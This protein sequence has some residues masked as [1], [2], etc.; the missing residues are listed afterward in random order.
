L[1]ACECDPVLL[2]AH[3]NAVN[4]LRKLGR[5]EEAL[6]V[7]NAI[8][9]RH[10][11]AAA[12]L[13]NAG[14]LLRDLLRPREAIDAYRRAIALQPALAEAHCNLGTL[15][16]QQGAFA[17][18]IAAFKEALALAPDL[19][20]A[21]CNLGAAYE[22]LGQP[23]E[24]AAAYRR[25]LACDP[26][27]LGVRLQIYHQR[28]NACDWIGLDI[29]APVIAAALPTCRQ[30]IVPFHLLNMVAAP[31]LHL[32][33]ARL[34]AS[35][36][37]VK[38]RFTHRQPEADAK[39]K[40]RLKIGYLSAD[41]S[42][43][44]TAHLAIDLFETHD[45]DKFEIIAYSYGH[46]DGSAMR[47]RLVRAFDTFIDLRSFDDRQAARKIFDDGV[48][49]LVELKGYTQFAR[50]G[51]AAHRP[52]PV[53]VN[54]LG[55]PGTMGADFIDYIIADPIVLPMDEQVHYAEKIVHLPDCYQPNDRARQIADLAPTRRACGLP[56]EGFVFCCFNHSYKI[57]PDMF[58]IW[59]RLLRKVDGSVLWLFDSYPDVR[60]NL[61]REARDRGV[62]PS[63][64]I[65]APR[66]PTR[67]HWARL[68]CADLFLD[69]LPYSAHTT[70]SE[71][72]WVGLPVLTLRGNTFA[73]RVAASLLAAVGLPELITDARDEYESK[74][75]YLATDPSALAA[76]KQKLISNRQT[77]PLFDTPRFTRHIEAAYRRMWEIW[78][79]GEEVRGFRIPHH[80]GT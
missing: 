18:A 22:S 9:A 2:D 76:L 6:A 54:F 25:A 70:A 49:I 12:P 31:T 34:W 40:S 63:R 51:I 39:T 65:F 75:L 37:G 58:D 17:E 3:L 29:E 48:D 7:C 46:D 45:R 38:E 30:P 80:E 59:M 10:P 19:A 14:N 20:D 24:S 13:F 53:Q 26:A 8:A 55:Y 33:C 64:L 5:F 23:A 28:R 16:L 21:H 78:V 50:S 36:I 43:H 69:T 15:L 68:T 66:V 4:L 47:Q 42:N 35:G 44:A 73:G 32:N 52:A 71:A 1:R 60:A 72:L 67:E 61:A 74:A 77:A 62:D 79:A 56:D 11:Q 57:T 41:F 27:R